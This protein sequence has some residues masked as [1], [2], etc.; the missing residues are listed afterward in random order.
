LTAPGATAEVVGK[1]ERLGG[2]M[3]RLALAAR[4]ATLSFAV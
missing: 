4:A 2:M 1:T 3:P